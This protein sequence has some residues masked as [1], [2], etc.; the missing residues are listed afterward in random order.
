M[1]EKVREEI[2]NTIRDF[3][4][5]NMEELNNLFYTDAF[6]K[7]SLRLFI[8]AP[9]SGRVATRDCKFGDVL[10]PKGTKLIISSFYIHRNEFEKG[11]EFIPERWLNGMIGVTAKY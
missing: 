8:P 4:H 5:F 3:E 10:I 7:E 6:I 2:M 1:Q 11:D 9:H